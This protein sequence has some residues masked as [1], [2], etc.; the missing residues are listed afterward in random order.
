MFVA[1]VTPE[2][3]VPAGTKRVL[4]QNEVEKHPSTPINVPELSDHLAFHPNRCFVD[5]LITGLTHGFLVGLTMLPSSVYVR[6]KY[7]LL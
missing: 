3:F 5:F 4:Q 2:L 1:I 7:S 6:K